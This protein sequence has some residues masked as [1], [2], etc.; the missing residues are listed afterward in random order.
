[1]LGIQAQQ[2][3]DQ[4]SSLK[5]EK[6][7][8]P[9][10]SKNVSWNPNLEAIRY[11]PCKDVIDSMP[12]SI[13][14]AL[15]K[16]VEEWKR[17]RS[18]P[19]L[20]SKFSLPSPSEAELSRFQT[21]FPTRFPW[22]AAIGP[23]LATGGSSHGKGKEGVERFCLPQVAA[24]TGSSRSGK[25]VAPVGH[26]PSGVGETHKLSTPA[27]RS[28]LERLM[29]L[30]HS[31][32]IKELERIGSIIQLQ[33]PTSESSVPTSRSSARTLGELMRLPQETG[34][35]RPVASGGEDDKRL[36]PI[37][38]SRM[39]VSAT[40]SASASRPPV[41]RH[42]KDGRNVRVVHFHWP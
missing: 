9:A 31:D 22:H 24:T 11:L 14:A 3:M 2:L 25:K 34:L 12:I 38:P 32:A 33:P 7:K 6:K 30:S 16:D 28:T 19:P 10:T 5:N 17:N 27:K 4:K 13:G 1:M 23:S 37:E 39:P 8:D 21:C 15:L 18:C 26:G 42:A 20:P 41:A 29:P 36:E 35:S 40:T